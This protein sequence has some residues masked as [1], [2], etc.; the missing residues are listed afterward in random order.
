MAW[1]KPSNSEVKPS[2]GLPGENNA[3]RALG[4]NEEN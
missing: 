3:M 4:D 2:N 1:G